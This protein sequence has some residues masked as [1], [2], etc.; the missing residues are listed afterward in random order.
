MGS[1]QAS[2]IFGNENDNLLG[3]PLN[4]KKGATREEVLIPFQL[5][6]GRPKFLSFDILDLLNQAQS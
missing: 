1:A 6:R 5:L 3:C 2:G 4:D